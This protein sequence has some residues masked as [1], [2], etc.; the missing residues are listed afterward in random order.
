MARKRRHTVEDEENNERWLI[1][2]A[3]FITLLFAFFVVMYSVSSVNEGKYRVLSDS[4]ESAFRHSTTRFQSPGLIQPFNP[5][6]ANA[7]YSSAEWNV[8]PVIRPPIQIYPVIKNSLQLENEAQSSQLE[9]DIEEVM[10]D[11]INQELISVSRDND[12]VEIEIKSSVLYGS[13]SAKMS[14]ESIHILT[15]IAEKVR[16]MN[17]IINVEGFTDNIPIQSSLYPSNWELSAARAA[18]VVHLFDTLGIDPKRLAAIGYGEHR[19]LTANDTQEGRLNNRRV[20]LV[21]KPSDATE[22]STGQ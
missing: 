19:P 16:N 20:V 17:H 1:S 5:D 10:S 18:S 12:R 14:G 9:E 22:L 13:G 6:Q 15:R 3:D 4:I 21:V 11:L 2:Y 7:P 8:I